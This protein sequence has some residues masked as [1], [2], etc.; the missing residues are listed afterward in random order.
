MH[1]AH[2]G[3][4]GPGQGADTARGHPRTLGAGPPCAEQQATPRFQVL[5][6]RQRLQAEALG[7]RGQH[8]GHQGRQQL[9]GE[10]FAQPAGEEGA[11]RFLRRVARWDKGLRQQPQQVEP[12][13]ARGPEQSRRRGGARVPLTPLAQPAG[14]PGARG[15]QDHMQVL[16]QAVQGPVGTHPQ[17]LG[18]ALQATRLALR[19]GPGQGLRPA[20][21]GRSGFPHLNL[22]A[23]SPQVPGRQE[24]GDAASQDEGAAGF[25]P[26][27]RVHAAPEGVAFGVW[28]RKPTGSLFLGAGLETVH[29]AEP[30]LDVG[31][32]PL[33]A[34]AGVEQGQ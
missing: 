21:D 3:R 30:G 33:Q 15:P 11:Q 16:Q 17:A 29:Q 34:A 4:E 22:A 5:Q 13:Q 23:R 8:P 20:A 31:Q 6:A 14:A 10:A 24:A 26:L 32:V 28:D 27:V 18:P 25:I 7:W 12:A 19:T 9:P 2:L 1:A